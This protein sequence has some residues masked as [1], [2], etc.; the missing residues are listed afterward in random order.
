VV[1]SLHNA[2]SLTEMES[3]MFAIDNIDDTF[4]VPN[5]VEIYNQ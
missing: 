5:T 1:L 2:F 4:V 3:V